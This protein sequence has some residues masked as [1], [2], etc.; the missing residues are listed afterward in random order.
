MA[1]IVKGIVRFSVVGVIAGAGLALV[2][3]QVRPGSVGAFM[4]HVGDSVG[5]T[6]DRTIDDTAALRAQISELEAQYPR[7]I[8]EVRSD[9]NEVEEQIAQLRRDVQ[10][11]RRV[12]ELTE[13]DLGE[14]DAGIE[15]ARS[16]STGS[17][18]VR[19]SF[20]G[21]RV[22][23]DS[24][25]RERASISQTHATHERRV[26]ELSTELGY[27]TGQR[28]QLAELL[29][30]LE[31]ERSEFKAQLA[32]LDAQVDS[33]ARNERMIAMMEERQQTIDEHSRYEAHSLDQLTSRLERVRSEQEQKL[34]EIASREVDHGYVD[35][36][37]YLIDAERSSRSGERDAGD[38]GAI[39][40][41]PGHGD[42]QK[43]D[44]KNCER[45]AGS[46]A[47]NT[48]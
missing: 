9:L 11:S 1:G 30:R 33:I 39:R 19:V 2:A 20:E 40:W 14:L 13:A 23:L 42:E 38:A 46:I 45:D 5:R 28:D 10:V 6:I 37:E 44:D 15:S 41:M 18:M 27:L 36:A 29:A 31:R 7:K 47:S 32:Q 21:R 34:R 16:S 12:V 48:R 35:E 3:N 8:A 22:A 25:Y 43:D 24:A 26:E 4:S 17:G